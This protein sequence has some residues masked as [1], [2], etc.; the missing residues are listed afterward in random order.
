ME[1]KNPTMVPSERRSLKGW[2]PAPSSSQILPHLRLAL[3][4][5]SSHNTSQHKVIAVLFQVYKG[6]KWSTQPKIRS[7]ARRWSHALNNLNHY[8]VELDNSVQW[9]YM[10]SKSASSVNVCN[11]ASKKNILILKNKAQTEL[12]ERL[13][14]VIVA[15]SLHPWSHRSRSHAKPAARGSPQPLPVWMET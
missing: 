14:E 12:F 6:L 3:C 9:K 4:P 2:P 1:T 8:I 10:L 13:R 15:C 5:L 11:H 7:C